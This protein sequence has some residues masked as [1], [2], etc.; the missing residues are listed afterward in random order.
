M[1]K[2]QDLNKTV[3]WISNKMI[4]QGMQSEWQKLDYFF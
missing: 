3:E 4:R 1:K 2:I